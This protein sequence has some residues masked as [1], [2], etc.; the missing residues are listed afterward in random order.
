MRR[1]ALDAAGVTWLE[2]S[3]PDGARGWAGGSTLAP[4]PQ[5]LALAP[6]ARRALVRRTAA[7]GPRAALVLRDRWGRN[8]LA[9]GSRA[10]L[11][12]ASVT[13][14]AT[15]A[16]AI[17]AGPPATVAARRILAPSDNERA[18]ALS[19]R[20]G[21]G[22]AARGARAAQE[23][24][25]ALGADVRLVDGSGLSPAN[26][27]S[28]AEIADLL[29]SLR[30]T[31]RFRTLFRG[32]PVAGRT[33]TLEDRMQGTAAEGRVRAKTGSLFDTPVSSLAGYVW[34]A[35]SGLAPER[36]W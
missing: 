34:P 13:K 4:V 18:Q 3:F 6:L 26:R 17:Q 12:L 1:A 24:A 21:G 23:A 31:P 16:A 28:A 8:L 9:V 7:L 29:L 11:S 14:L 36:R 32:L 35:G 27:A 33:G 2:L 15:V 25:A 5:P 19:N 20:I 10:P 30:D 22:S